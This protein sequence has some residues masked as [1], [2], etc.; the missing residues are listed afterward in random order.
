MINPRQHACYFEGVL[1]YKTAQLGI[2]VEWK[3]T[4]PTKQ[5][6]IFGRLEKF[7]IER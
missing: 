3:E 7:L 6:F 2:G 5:S 1:V 4:Q